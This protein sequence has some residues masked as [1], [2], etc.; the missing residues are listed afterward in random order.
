M[1]KNNAPPP[2]L[3][4][5]S[6]GKPSARTKPPEPRHHSLPQASSTAVALKVAESDPFAGLKPARVTR[7]AATQNSSKSQPTQATRRNSL[8]DELFGPQR[9]T[10]SAELRL[11]ILSD[12]KDEDLFPE[13]KQKQRTLASNAAAAR[14]SV[15]LFPWEKNSNTAG[16]PAPIKSY[17]IA[18][19]S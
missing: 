13:L 17:D 19:F 8:F 14:G 6:A 12:F 5:Q 9:Q 15:G 2:P 7:N 10:Q 18:Q 1:N 3:M 4:S 16:A 11:K